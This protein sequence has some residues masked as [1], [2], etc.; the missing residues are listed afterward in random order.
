MDEHGRE[1]RAQYLGERAE[2]C[3]EGQEAL[4]LQPRMSKPVLE[5]WLRAESTAASSRQ[6]ASSQVN[7]LFVLELKLQRSQPRPAKGLLCRDGQS[8]CLRGRSWTLQLRS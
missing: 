4:R 5:V 6:P 3:L 8:S 2:A 7:A 1:G